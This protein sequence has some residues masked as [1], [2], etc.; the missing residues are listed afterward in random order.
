M[1]LVEEYFKNKVDW[2]I[3][4]V[5]TGQPFSPAI[6][7]LPSG[8]KNKAAMVAGMEVIHESGT[9]KA[10]VLT[11]TAECPTYE[12]QI[13]SVCIPQYGTIPGG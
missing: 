12:R 11:A 8:L 9:H 3:C 5:D 10:N 2:M 13:G 4:F 1:T 6:L 7:S